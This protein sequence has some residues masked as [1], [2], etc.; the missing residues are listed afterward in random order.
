MYVI[1]LERYLKLRINMSWTWLENGIFSQARVLDEGSTRLDIFTFISL[2]Q[3][4][5]D[6]PIYVMNTGD[7]FNKADKLVSFYYAI[8]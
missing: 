6:K 7:F 4:L 1:T 2:I 5:V 8:F 3:C